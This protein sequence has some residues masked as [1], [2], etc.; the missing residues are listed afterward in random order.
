[1]AGE[2]RVLRQLHARRGAVAEPLFRHEG[3]AELAALGDRE[4]AGGVAVDDDVA[5]ARR[6]TLAGQRREQFVLAVAGDAGDAE[7]FAALDL[8]RDAR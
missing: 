7:D 2:Q 5:V 3:G 4:V 1:M 8:E 6:E